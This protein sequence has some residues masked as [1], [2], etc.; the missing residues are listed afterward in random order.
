MDA[1][2]MAKLLRQ[3]LAERQIELSHSD[4]LELVARQFGLS[5]WNVLSAK[6]ENASLGAE[7]QLPE[8]WV[9]SGKSPQ[10]Y[11]AGLDA[12]NDSTV[13]IECLPQ[14]VGQAGPQ[15]F[16][17]VMQSV[18]ATAFRG[19]R[20]RLVGDIR[21]Q[22]AVFG[23]TIWFRV[24]GPGGTIYFDN[25]ESRPDGPIVGTQDWTARHV[26]F[27]I[28]EAATSLHYGFFL[29]G[30][31]SCWSRRFSL[32]AVDSSVPLTPTGGAYLPRPTNLD[33]KRPQQN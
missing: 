16:C 12:V 7:L 20:L 1:K 24:D 8:G 3:A 28:P 5:N 13:L 18:A 2:L 30:T 11:R 26:V 15:D 25:L 22:D 32:E 4:C 9:K 31:G 10:F 29:K 33:F 27:D 6:I 23:A 14:F 17:T 19:Q 21:T